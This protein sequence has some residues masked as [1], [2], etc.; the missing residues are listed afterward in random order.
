M[1]GMPL[2]T[3]ARYSCHASP[4]KLASSRSS[5]RILPSKKRHA[6]A[7]NAAVHSGLHNSSC[8]PTAHTI[9][10]AYP[11]CRTQAYTPP[12]TSV[13][14]SRLRVWIRCVKLCRAWT[15]AGGSGSGG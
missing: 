10:P 15:C 11:G 3:R 2:R 12:V 1:P 13:C 9:H 7:A 5:A 14:S 4:K 8:V 6:A